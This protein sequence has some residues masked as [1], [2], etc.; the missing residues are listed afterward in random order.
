MDLIDTH[1]RGAF[2]DPL[3]AMLDPSLPLTIEERDEWGDPAS[4]AHTREVMT[5]Y[6]PYEGLRRGERYPAIMLAAA[7]LDARVPLAQSL[8]YASRLRQRSA[9]GSSSSSGHDEQAT[10]DATPAPAPVVLHV[11]ASGGH[12][13]EGGRYRRFEQASLELGFLIHSVGLGEAPSSDW[14]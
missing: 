12:L 3:G 8:R 2:L 5:R 13:G 9:A 4:C 10:H 6:S 14:D 7:E 1:L 11:R